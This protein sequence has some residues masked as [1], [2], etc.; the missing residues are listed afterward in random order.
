MKIS[1]HSILLLLTAIVDVSTYAAE[2]VPTPSA[3]LVVGRVKKDHP[4][5]LA[6]KDDFAKLRAEIVTNSTLTQWH[7]GL[8][9]QADRILSEPPSR[10]EIPDGLRL[11][12]TSRRVLTRVQT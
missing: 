12:A 7:A 5:L 1:A 4:R 9:Q 10:Y 2:T 3:A 11:L 8:R 6:T